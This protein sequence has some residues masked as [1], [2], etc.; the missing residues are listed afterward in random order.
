MPAARPAPKCRSEIGA[1][2]SSFYEYCCYRAVRGPQDPPPPREQRRQCAPHQFA[3]GWKRLA[4]GTF[5]QPKLFV[6]RR[7]GSSPCFV[8]R[9]SRAA[10]ARPSPL[11]ALSQLRLGTF[12][13]LRRLP[14]PSLL[15]RSRG[16]FAKVALSGRARAPVVWRAAHVALQRRPSVSPSLGHGWASVSSPV[17]PDSEAGAPTSERFSDRPSLQISSLSPATSRS[18]SPAWEGSRASAS[19]AGPSEVGITR[20]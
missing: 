12:P 2:G 6:V 14:S 4:P 9:V 1:S 15:C 16:H 3:G 10:F 13:A 8:V 11:R 20:V 17:G 19:G 18:T 5:V 7:I